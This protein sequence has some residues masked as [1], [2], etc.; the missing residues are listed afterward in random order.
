MSIIFEKV[1]QSYQMGEVSIAAAKDVSFAIQ[2][3]ELCVMLGPSG[4][5][6]TTVLN[7]LGGMEPASSGKIMFGDLEVTSMSER[8]LTEYR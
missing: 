3:G 7:L 1:S 6:K 2:E 8:Q 4:A 5:G